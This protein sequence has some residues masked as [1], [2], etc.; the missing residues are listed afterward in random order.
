MQLQAHELLVA[1]QTDSV[2]I[3]DFGKYD[4]PV[5]LFA[6]VLLT[7][8]LLIWRRVKH[9]SN[10]FF[11]GSV[12]ARR[13]RNKNRSVIASSFSF[14]HGNFSNSKPSGKR[15]GTLILN[16]V[17]LG[18]QKCQGPFCFDLQETRPALAV[19]NSKNRPGLRFRWS[20]RT[21]FYGCAGRQ[22]QAFQVVVLNIKQHLRYA[23]GQMIA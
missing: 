16:N 23:S 14:R 3:Q 18:L 17:S 5:T 19:E 20:L 4:L 11:G 22:I 8:N 6:K 2:I 13:K 21:W 1:I 12:D 15:G 9:R 7:E 10:Q